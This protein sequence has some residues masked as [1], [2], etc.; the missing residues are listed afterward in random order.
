MGKNTGKIIKSFILTALVLSI[1][2]IWANAVLAETVAQL[3]KP[4][5]WV[6]DYTNTLSG[7]DISRLTSVCEELE[8]ANTAELAIVIINT[9]GSQ[10]IESFAQEL[11]TTWGIGKAGSDNGVLILVA[12]DDREWRVHLGYGVEGAISDS[13]AKR[14]MENEAVPEFRANDFGEGL[15]KAALQIKSTLEGE[16]YKPSGALGIGAI[17]AMIFTPMAI[18]IFVGILVWLS[19]RVTCP[20]CGSRVIELSDREILES[21]YAHSGIRKRDFECTVCHHLF[22]R[23]SIIPMLVEASKGGSGGSSGGFFGGGWS[24]GGSSGGSFGGFSGGSSGGGGA[25]GGW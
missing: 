20:R 11:Y 16:T 19:V 5:G 3:G 2:L 24:S 7:T 1:G 22:S 9:T 23:M 8:N 21:N 17:L 13:L 4:T 14:I 18:I 12:M 6:N 10:T 25:S 15:Y